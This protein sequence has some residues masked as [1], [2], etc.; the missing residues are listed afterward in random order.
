MSDLMVAPFLALVFYGTK[1]PTNRNIF[2]KEN[3]DSLKGIF[4]LIILFGHAY[5]LNQPSYLFCRFN[6][7]G[8]Y[9]CA[10][11]FFI[12]GYGLIIQYL[13][14]KNY[15]LKSF[16]KKRFSSILIPAINGS[17]LY[18]IIKFIFVDDYS[19]ELIFDSS[20]HGHTP[21]IDNSWFIIQL[22]YLYIIFY[23][24]FKY[25][26]K[27]QNKISVNF[28]ILI[29]TISVI[30]TILIVKMINWGYNWYASILAFPF[31]LFAGGNKSYFENILIKYRKF[32][33]I[34]SIFFIIASAYYQVFIK[35]L[36]L[37]DVS[38]NLISMIVDLISKLLFVTMIFSTM[39]F[40][41]VG[42]IVLNFIKNISYELYIIHGLFIYVFNNIVVVSNDL[43]KICL[44]LISSIMVAFLM[45]KI[46]GKL[47]KKLV[48]END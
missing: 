12:S 24:T 23:F 46:D 28:V 34:F 38:D 14:K 47:V 37:I 1:K 31:G 20:L 21:V 2:N 33:I 29:I 16:L 11:F 13:N 4:T 35:R 25:Y 18:L 48:N 9:A 40:I 30:V 15:Y 36:F 17:I 3:T 19:L 27:R 43:L 26:S 42:N 6:N 8:A 10:I 45:S 44:I 32:I 7:L 39:A 41:N 5:S 22:I